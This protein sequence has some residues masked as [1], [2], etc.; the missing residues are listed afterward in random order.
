[1]AQLVS[2]NAGVLQ[3]TPQAEKQFK[4]KKFGSL[5][6]GIATKFLV[7]WAKPL[8]ISFIVALIKEA[9]KKESVESF[10]QDIIH[11]LD[12]DGDGKI[13]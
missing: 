6:V 1:M 12:S 7:G 2:I 3:F 4:P 11:E 8:L 10:V 9:A 13:D 5:V